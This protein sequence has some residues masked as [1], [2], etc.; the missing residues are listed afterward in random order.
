MLSPL[1]CALVQ[2]QRVIEHLKAAGQIGVQEDLW[3]SQLRR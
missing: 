3:I 2:I 1:E